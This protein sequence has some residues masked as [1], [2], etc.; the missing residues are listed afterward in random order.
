MKPMIRS[1]IYPSGYHQGSHRD[2]VKVINL[3]FSFQKQASKIV[4]FPLW[5]QRAF[6]LNFSQLKHLKLYPLDYLIQ[7]GYEI[8]IQIMF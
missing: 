7:H 3:F 5:P 6:S 4:I 8:N 1:L 2:N